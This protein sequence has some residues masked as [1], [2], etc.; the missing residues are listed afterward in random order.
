MYSLLILPSRQHNTNLFFGYII[1]IVGRC[2][3]AIFGYIFERFCIEYYCG[4]CIEKSASTLHYALNKA[5][6]I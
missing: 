4:F 5:F 1:L 6:R 2:F 3:R